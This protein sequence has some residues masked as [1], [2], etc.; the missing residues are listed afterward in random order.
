V[1]S[2]STCRIRTRS[3]DRTEHERRAVAQTI[4]TLVVVA[5][6]TGVHGAAR[7]GRLGPPPRP[8]ARG[9]GA[10]VQRE[11]ATLGATVAFAI[12]TPRAATITREESFGSLRRRL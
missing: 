3:A 7:E 8:S 11:V 12:A 10:F 2:V 1:P 6:E 5:E 9:V 4:T